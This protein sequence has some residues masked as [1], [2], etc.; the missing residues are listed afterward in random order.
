MRYGF[1]ML[2]L[3]LALSAPRAEGPDSRQGLLFKTGLGLGVGFGGPFG[4]GVEAEW[5]RAALLAG[6]GTWGDE[7]SYEIG[8]RYYFT[9]AGTR[10]RPHAT[11]SYGATH[12][13]EY[14]NGIE[15]HTGLY[16]GFSFLGG[17]DHDFRRPGGFMMTYALGLAVPLRLTSE[18]A[19]R[20]ESTGQSE[21]TADPAFTLSIGIKY[22]F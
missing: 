9:D 18:D 4:A 16:Y 21:P 11:A 20:F 5:G 6:I 3:L 22:Q 14:S 7:V 10:L 15:S 13:I 8:A 12:I 19:D 2:V 17:F 1:M